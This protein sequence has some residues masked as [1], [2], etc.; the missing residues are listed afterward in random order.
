MKSTG[1]HDMSYM[2]TMKYDVL[3]DTVRTVITIFRKK[4]QQITTNGNKI[5]MGMGVGGFSSL[6]DQQAEHRSWKLIRGE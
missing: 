3:C 1:A 4:K 2:R 6:S 5:G